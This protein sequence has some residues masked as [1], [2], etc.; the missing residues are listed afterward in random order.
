MKNLFL[1]TT[2]FIFTIATFAQN[3]NQN[4]EKLLNG[5]VRGKITDS[6]T[7]KPIEYATVALVS[8]ADT[9]KIL[10]SLTDEKGF[11]EVE[12]VKVGKYFL[13]VYLIGYKLYKSDTVKISPAKAE[14]FIPNIKLVPSSIQLDDIKVQ[15]EK[16]QSILSLD[17]KIFEVDKMP[18]IAGGS[19]TNVLQQIPAVSVDMDGNINIRGSGYVTI[20]VNGK[21]FANA[22]ANPQSILEQ[23]PASSIERVELVTNPS[24]RYDAE[25]SGGIINI[26]LKKNRED[27]FNGQ[28]AVGFG[29]RDRYNE[30]VDKKNTINKSNNS[31]SINWKKGKWNLSSNYG[32]RYAQR[33][34]H[35][36]PNLRRNYDIDTA[37][38]YDNVISQRSVAELY[39]HNHL[40]NI[41]GDY[42]ISDKKVI[43]FKATGG[44]NPNA[45]PENLTY[46]FYREF[47]GSKTQI[48]PSDSLKNR[49]LKNYND[50]YNV[51]A[52][53]GYRKTYDKAGQEL[54]IGSSSSYSENRGN[55][56]FYQQN[57]IGN[58][59]TN[60]NTRT[61]PFG[62]N[63]VNVLQ[64]DYIHPISEKT[65]LEMGLKNTSRFFDNDFK[66]DTLTGGTYIN[67]TNKSNRFKYNDIISAAYGIVNQG[68]NY[69]LSVQLGLRIEQTFR[70]VEQV[71]LKRKDNL[72]FIDFFP[73]GV[74]QKKL[75]NDQEL[76]LTYSRRINRPQPNVLNP[77][78]SYNDPFNLVIG[79]PY[80]KPEYIHVIELGYSKNWK[81]HSFQTTLYFRQTDGSVQRV[82]RVLPNQ[83]SI[84]EY[85]NVGFLRAI[86]LELIG[87]N[88]LTKWWNITSNVNIYQNQISGVVRG[89]DISR[90]NITWNA[91]IISNMKVWKGADFQITGFYMAP[92]AIA[93]GTF[94]GMNGVDVGFRKDIIPNKAF[95]TAN[96]SDIFNIRQFH[97]EQSGNLFYADILRKRETRVL[98][99]NFTYKFGKELKMKT[100]RNTGRPDGGDGGGGGDF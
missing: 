80:L 10:A 47:N 2:T 8:Y 41:S 52:N 13:K 32:Y 78:P 3:E 14:I 42:N 30:S 44:Y 93:Q 15:G 36:Y 50:G 54:Y 66:F 57:I 81:D 83:A 86:G 1:F 18:A 64:L 43:E 76:R 25:S 39:S 34:Q 73:S 97:V 67:S 45:E 53:L 20:W 56:N 90:D 77:F 75:L 100:R 92:V 98:T 40:L 68:F 26:I 16:E 96:I 37:G 38:L 17:K 84:T 5:F 51:D 88:K 4:A 27:G 22:G 48:N 74:I 61:N 58:S 59:I 55:S 71:T 85:A 24:A 79:N 29:T 35:H 31:I 65:K 62:T 95:V 33:W 28:V 60:I 69:G 46:D 91:R 72:E 9:S 82:R 70:T 89:Q 87:K 6:K 49:N 23:I 94:Q 63:Q 21:P 12:K 19:A 7:S 99:V 11:F